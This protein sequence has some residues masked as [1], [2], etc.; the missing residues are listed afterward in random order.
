MAHT[1]TPS[2]KPM[3][4]ERTKL[5]D[6]E[7]VLPP[8]DP[9]TNDVMEEALDGADEAEVPE[10]DPAATS[11]DTVGAYL[12][13]IGRVPLLSREQE[14]E[15]AK[16]IESGRQLLRDEMFSLPLAATYVTAICRALRTGEV[17][18]R[19]ILE[20]DQ[21]D[22]GPSFDE[23]VR[24]LIKK[25][26][27]LEELVRA[28]RRRTSAA[29]REAAQRDI[30]A[31]LRG[32]ELSDRHVAAI[33]G[34]VL[35][36]SDAVRRHQRVLAKRAQRAGEHN[37]AKINEAQ[38]ALKEIEETVGAPTEGIGEIMTRV[39]AAQ[40]RI[41]AARQRFVEANLRLVV[42]IARRHAHRG[43]D[44][45][46]LVQEGNIGLMRAVDKFEYQRGFK[47]STY[48]TWWI[49]QAI[50]RAI[51]DQARTIR[52][53]VHMAEARGKVTR[54]T[55]ELRRRLEREPSVEEVAAASGLSQE[56]VRKAVHL[57]KEPVSLDTPMGDDEERALADIIE[58]PNAPAPMEA[59]VAERVSEQTRGVLST[60]SAR[61]ET[62]LRMRFGI[63][64]RSEYTLEEIGRE[65]AITRERVRQIESG[66]L[67]KLRNA[68]NGR[69][70]AA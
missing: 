54:T 15:L 28:R 55:L 39:R 3:L 66:G 61:E 11:L 2:I 56:Q 25:G 24:I 47:F 58:D 4:N 51:L 9:V 22:Q 43:M 42:A 13:T 30:A 32:M 19:A 41:E 17:D 53:P 8:A 27:Q 38:A 35:D 69:S 18:S 57:V 6:L 10:I 26:E 68:P 63:G 23:R 48:A 49:R 29:G 67:R 60:L 21:S 5:E 20:D 12:N 16:E 52:I 44:L 14:V 33:M 40:A 36:A 64:H 46:D 45:L 59:V 65:F 37:K 31:H 50:T 70:M 1:K 62:I 7:D 34:Q